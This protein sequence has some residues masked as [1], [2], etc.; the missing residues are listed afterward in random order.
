MAPKVLHKGRADQCPMR[1]GCK[2]PYHSL[3]MHSRRLLQSTILE[4][5]TQGSRRNPMSSCPHVPDSKQASNHKDVNVVTKVKRAKV[6]GKRG[7]IANIRPH[8]KTM[9]NETQRP[10]ERSSSQH[11][12]LNQSACQNPLWPWGPRP[13]AKMLAYRFG[14]TYAACIPESVPQGPLS[15]AE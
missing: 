3:S 15:Y 5:V 1:Q 8:T 7:D 11:V 12:W 6:R 10:E 13:F 4:D 9:R 14:V 2:R